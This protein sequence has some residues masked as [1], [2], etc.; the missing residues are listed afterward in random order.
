VK[1]ERQELLTGVLI[2]VFVALLIAALMSMGN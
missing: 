1:Q 2:G